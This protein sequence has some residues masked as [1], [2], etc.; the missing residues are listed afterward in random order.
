[1]RVKGYTVHA[2]D[3]NGK[4]LCGVKPRLF[5]GRPGISTKQNRLGITCPKC[6]R[7]LVRT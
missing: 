5:M 7:L 1:M 4:T 2:V 3:V 6:E